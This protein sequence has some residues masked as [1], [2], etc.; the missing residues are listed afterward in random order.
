MLLSFIEIKIKYKIT[1]NIINLQ[2]WYIIEYSIVLKTKFYFI[3][4][5]NEHQIFY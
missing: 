3:L 4:S 1:T 2:L 5:L